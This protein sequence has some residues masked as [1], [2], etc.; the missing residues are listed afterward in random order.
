MRDNKKAFTQLCDNILPCVVGKNVWDKLV[1][2]TIVSKIATA[3]DEAWALLV[4]E[5]SWDLWK[6][7]A[8]APDGRVE[9][10]ERM[11]TKWTQAGNSAR[12]NEGWG[13]KGIPRFNKLMRT[14]GPDRVRNSAV[15]IDYLK[16]KM[17]T[18]CSRKAGKR[19]RQ[20]EGEEAEDEG[21]DSFAELD[22]MD[23]T[24]I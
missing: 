13:D 17:E 19:K 2:Q 11:E 7:M 4:M 24:A 20:Q 9:E 15:E 18:L 10:K 1:D 22:E 16:H 21:M 6:Q 23:V 12:K 5:N 8:D 3:T 14:I